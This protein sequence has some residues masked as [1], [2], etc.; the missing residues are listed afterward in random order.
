MKNI[1]QD[2]DSASKVMA[3]CE[4]LQ[5]VEIVRAQDRALIDI[6]FNGKRPYT[7]DEVNKHQIRINVNWNEGTKVLQDANRQVNNATL[8][9]GKFCNVSCNVGPVEKRDEWGTKFTK[10]FNRLLKRGKC[11]KKHMN[12]RKDR[13]AAVCLH[14]IG[15]L[16]W[17]KGDDLLP[18]FIPLED[19]LI[20]TD[21]SLDL[22]NLMHFACN[23][24][25]TQGEFFTLTHGENVQKGWNVKLVEAILEALKQP[26]DNNTYDLLREPEKWQENFKQNHC[27]Y[28]SDRVPRVKLRAFFFQ[29]PDDK[30]WY[31]RIV[32]RE[33]PSGLQIEDNTKEKFVFTSDIPFAE[34][35]E[36]VLHIQYGDCSVV[37]PLKYHSVR[38]LGMLLYGPVE[39]SNRLKCSYVQHTLDNMKPLMRIQNP[40]D[41]ARAQIVDLFP[42]AVLE[43]GATFVPQAERHQ[44]DPNLAES[45]MAQMR[46]VMSENSASFVQDIND[47]TSKEMTATEAQARLQSVNVAV[48]GMLESMYVQE[49]PY[50]E[51]LIRRLCM[52]NPTD[53]YIKKF[54]EMCKKDGI[55]ENLL[56][57]DNWTVEMERVLGAG[58]NMLGQQEASALLSQSQRFDPQ[59]Q[60][61]IL[62]KWT[63][64]ITRNPDLAN[65]L[66]PIRPPEASDGTQE[67]EDVFG[68]LMLGVPV[69]FREGIDQNGYVESLIGMIAAKVGQFNKM[70]QIAG[71]LPSPQ[72][73]YG[74]QVAL[75]DATQHVQFINQNPE[76]GPK[77][78]TYMDAVGRLENEVKKLAQH[79][80][81]QEQANKPDD[82]E[83]MQAQAKAQSTVLLAQTK[84]A[85]QK[86]THQQK[87]MMSQQKFE[88]KM[89]QDLEKF[90]LQMAKEVQQAKADI[91]GSVAKTGAEIQNATAKAEAAPQKSQE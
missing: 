83:M 7:E 55:P 51:E 70:E 41:R 52:S 34:E 27:Y 59:S 10:N 36:Q 43:D 75:Q 45:A 71:K 73:L 26:T 74:L 13:N 54:R 14:G 67:A 50:F 65:E 37:A 48:G 53:P 16:M 56:K 42:Y 30:K 82:G 46:Q 63:S 57:P 22:D 20:P 35:I 32:V 33:W 79:V 47:G 23:L 1:T 85:T 38:G 64:T 39:C 87:L 78:K 90:R 81:E 40:A 62:N 77:V 91:A 31:R 61:K 68:T 12:T 5:A 44:I 89:A 66:V 24:Y 3:I 15:P 58:D 9:T 6:M 19:L 69:S 72:E 60:R 11:G 17:M 76:Q 86:M 18:R 29:S 8:Y 25:L 80:A 28:N 4:T 88:Q 21:T 2:F 49:V 84:A